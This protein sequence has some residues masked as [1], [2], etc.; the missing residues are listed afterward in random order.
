MY[1]R[2]TSIMP[3]D[4]TQATALVVGEPQ[5]P[6]AQLLLEDLVFL[7]EVLDRPLLL[8]MDPA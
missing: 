7:D 6:A 2:R 3:E 4:D 1:R 5:P 8:A